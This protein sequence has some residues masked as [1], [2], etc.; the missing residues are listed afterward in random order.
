MELKDRMALT[1]EG[2]VTWA[3]PSKGAKCI[4]CK[5]VGKHP[6]PKIQREQICQLVFL[7]TKKKGVPFDARRA[8]ACSKY[9]QRELPA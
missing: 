4:T 1:V 8:T 5:N 6:K 9:E 2:Q 7:F 3:D